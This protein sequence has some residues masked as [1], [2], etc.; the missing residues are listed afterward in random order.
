[1]DWLKPAYGNMFPP[2]CLQL[3]LLISLFMKYA[4][5]FTLIV[6]L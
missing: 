5:F 6:E 4:V 3:R 1:M 2:L